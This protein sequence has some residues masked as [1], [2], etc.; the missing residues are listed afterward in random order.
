MGDPIHILPI[1]SAMI[2]CHVHKVLT[3][4]CPEH[5]GATA[6][7][8]KHFCQL[9]VHDAMKS[10]AA[11]ALRLETHLTTALALAE[12]RLFDVR[13]NVSHGG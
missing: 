10:I 1:G 11:G 5:A 3:Q 9:V 8:G 6:P 7:F 4:N 12:R 13:R 2:A